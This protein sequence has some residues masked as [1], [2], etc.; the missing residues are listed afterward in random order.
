MKKFLTLILCTTLLLGALSAHAFAQDEQTTT[1]ATDTQATDTQEAGAEQ[2]GATQTTLPEEASITFI[3]TSLGYA[4]CTFYMVMPQ[5]SNATSF[6]LYWGDANGKKLEGYTPFLT[7]TITTKDVLT[8]TSEAFSFPAAAKTALVYTYSEQFGE[9]ATPFIATTTVDNASGHINFSLP[10]TGKQVAEFVIVSDLHIG[11]GATAEK[12]LTAMLRDVLKVSP[13]A[14][15]ILV[16]GD[17]VE[18]GSEE[19]FQKLQQLH[20]S[21]A[22]AP[23]MY[24]GAGDRQY[25][26]KDYQYKADAFAQNLQTF[27]KYAGHPYDAK[28]ETPYYSYKLGN[29]LLV[30]IGADSY[31]NGNAV[32]SKEQLTWLDGVLSGTDEYDP[33][34]VIMHEPLP[35]TVSG[36]LTGQGYA[37]IHNHQELKAVLKKY[38]NLTV[39][40]GHTQWD[41]EAPNTMAYVSTNSRIFNTAGVAHLWNDNG[42]EGFEVAGC[43]GFYVTVYED[44]LLIRGRNFDTGEWISSAIYMYSIQP[45]PMQNTQQTTASTAKPATTTKPQEEETTEEP[46]PGLI[47]ELGTPLCILAGMTVVVFIIVFYKPKEQD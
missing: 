45:V 4:S 30:F 3:N 7:G 33:V 21:I 38:S 47:E 2:P 25:L 8:G 34:L 27:L 22:G 44:A 29:T 41:M 9:S 15:A 13:K 36:S 5:S 19:N 17:A 39:F 24:L 12:N 42:S 26:T 18:Y 40:S 6:K 35:A 28:V 11:S 1:A 37:N 10:E 20:A 23:P 14:N 46:K 16:A 32:Y 31:N 43:Q